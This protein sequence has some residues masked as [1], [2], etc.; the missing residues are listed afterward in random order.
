MSTRPTSKGEVTLSDTFGGRHYIIDEVKY[1]STTTPLSILSMP[2]INEWKM[3][4]GKTK[5]GLIAGKAS[6]YGTRIHDYAADILE[7]KLD[8]DGIEEL[9]PTYQTELKGILEWIEENVDEIIGVE[10]TVY[11]D[12]Y[13]L[14]GAVDLICTLKGRTGVYWCDWKTGRIKDEALLQLAAYCHLTVDCMDSEFEGRPLELLREALMTPYIEGRGIDTCHRLILSVKTNSKGIGVVKEVPLI[15][16]GENGEDI[17]L[18][19]DWQTYLKVLGVWRWY[20]LNRSLRAQKKAE[21]KKIKEEHAKGVAER[22]AIREAKK[23][24]KTNGAV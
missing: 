14:A 15:V 5:A 11:S 12:S 17:T 3:R 4:V 22:K 10:K 23:K 9:H 1:V 20:G 24:E 8:L 6:K 18:E 7:G 13:R 2:A 21:K 19:A 16:E